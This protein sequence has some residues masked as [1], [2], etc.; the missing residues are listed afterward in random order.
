MTWL[1]ARAH[2]MHVW[3]W[4]GIHEIG[5]MGNIDKP[6]LLYVF[7]SIKVTTKLKCPK[8][9]GWNAVTCLC[10][11]E[12]NSAIWFFRMC[13]LMM[14]MRIEF[15]FQGI[16]RSR[17]NERLCFAITVWMYDKGFMSFLFLHTNPS[18][19]SYYY[20]LYYI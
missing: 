13:H 4:N 1:A 12:H 16:H 9:K 8:L 15:L 11:I 18:Y 2:V 17:S 19:G 3:N 7:N 14:S 6:V 20:I 10:Y 5:G